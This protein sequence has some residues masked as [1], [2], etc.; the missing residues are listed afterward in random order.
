MPLVFP[1]LA[2][3]VRIRCMERREPVNPLLTP[4]PSPYLVMSQSPIFSRL[5]SEGVN[6]GG[7]ALMAYCVWYGFLAIHGGPKLGRRE[8]NN[9]KGRKGGI[10][11][12][13][14][15]CLYFLQSPLPHPVFYSLYC[16]LYLSICGHFSLFLS[17]S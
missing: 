9:E 5:W 17:I 12:R 4:L 11:S 3:S 1:P 6:M 14:I 10:L 2:A 13:L 16:V 8:I 15:P 7:N